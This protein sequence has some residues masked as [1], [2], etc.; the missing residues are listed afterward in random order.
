M[1]LVAP[2]HIA[3]FRFQLD[4]LRYTWD[5]WDL[6]QVESP[7]DESLLAKLRLLSQRANVAFC[8]ACAEWI[9]YPLCAV[10][11]DQL[12]VQRLETA[13]AQIIDPRYSSSLDVPPDDWAGPLKGPVLRAVDLVEFAVDALARDQSPVDMAATASKLTTHLLVQETALFFGWQ[14]RVVARLMEH[15]RLDADEMMGDVVPREALNLEHSFDPTHT[16]ELMNAFLQRLCESGNPFLCPSDEMAYRGYKGPY[17]RFDEDY[18][19][20]LRFEW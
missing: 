13:W 15:Y 8:I 16:Q 9:V 3:G 5:D 6:D 1:V 20:K 19:R 2:P 10:L 12:P 18:D 4:P 7:L 17:C 11:K 14:N